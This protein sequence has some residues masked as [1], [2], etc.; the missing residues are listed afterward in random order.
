RSILQDRE[1]SVW[2]ATAQGLNRLKDGKFTSYSQKDGLAS[3]S[4]LSLYEDAGGSLWIGTRLGLNCLKNGRL[5]TYTSA[6]NGLSED[7][8][9]SITA[10]RDGALWVGTDSGLNRLS[11]GRFESYS[12]KDGLTDNSVWVLQQDHGG[13]LWIGTDG[14]LDCW[15]DGRFT[16]F[17]TADGLASNVIFSLYEDSE[18]TLWIGTSGGLSRLKDGKISTLTRKDGLFDNTIFRILEDSRANL[19]MSCNKG[20][21]QV[22][23]KDLNRLANKEITRVS[24]AAYGTADGMK[25]HE[26]NGG[27]QPAGCRT[28]DGRLWFPTTRGVAVIDPDNLHINGLPPPVAVERVFADGK[29]IDARVL[30]RFPP[31]T[32]KFEFHFT[33]MS[34]LAPEKIRFKYKLEGF[35]SEW[36]DAGDSRE[37]GYTNLRPG[38]YTFRVIACNNDGVWN[39]AGASFGF[40]LA[41]HFYQSVWFYGLLVIGAAMIALTA[42]RVRVGQI[43]RRFSA[44]LAERGR[45]A[46]ELHDTLAQGLVA[47]GLQ[48][49]AASEKL[50]D[51]PELVEQHLELAQKMIRGSL[52]EARR[53]VWDLRPQALQGGDLAAALSDSARQMMAGSLIRL[54]FRVNGA[55]RTLPAHVESNLLRISQEALTNSVKHAGASGVTLELTFN[56][57]LVAVRVTD[58]GCGFD[59]DTAPSA[60]SGHFGLIGIGERVQQLG[61][62]MRLRTGPGQGTEVEVEVPLD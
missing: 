23:K 55:P 49:S 59:P 44:V 47:I 27:F 22:S 8:V 9:L 12:V 4:V 21:F 51:S 14:G 20:V 33:A 61:G 48:L 52:T 15:K 18:G 57:G 13:A 41:P 16:S 3:N 38:D 19:W 7:T 34:H 60:A 36:A 31:G 24:S 50:K 6:K 45:L 17:T 1:G 10:D 58:D 40:R 30:G 54:D 11:N 35:D 26:C 25:S 46:R 2:I 43:R 39:E 32:E 29:Q 5:T 56:N 28:L 62:R 53:S 42:Y 37:A